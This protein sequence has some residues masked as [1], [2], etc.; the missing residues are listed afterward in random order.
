[1]P[2]PIKAPQQITHQADY[3]ADCILNDN[4]VKM[5]GEEGLRDM[6]LMMQIYRS[7]GIKAA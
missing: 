3:F 5:S 7:A 1:M 2:E 4:P 6:E